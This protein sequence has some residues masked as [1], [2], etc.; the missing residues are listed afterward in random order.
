MGFAHLAAH[1]HR[2]HGACGFANL[3]GFGFFDHFADGV[4]NLAG[5]GVGDHLA[6]HM[7]DHLALFFDLGGPSDTR[8]GLRAIFTLH[9]GMA[10]GV[11]V[12][13]GCAFHERPSVAGA[14]HFA[15]ARGFAGDGVGTGVFVSFAIAIHIR[16]FHDAGGGVGDFLDDLFAFIATGGV[17][18]FLHTLIPIDLAHLARNFLHGAYRNFL[19][20]GVGDFFGLHL[21]HIAGDGD[22]FANRAATE[23]AATSGDGFDRVGGFG[24][25]AALSTLGTFRGIIGNQAGT[26]HGQA[27][28]ARHH[29]VG[30]GDP[31]ELLAHAGF[32]SGYGLANGAANGPGAGFSFGLPLATGDL[33]H[34]VFD[35]H[36]TNIVTDFLGVVLDDWLANVVDNFFGVVFTNLFADLAGLGVS[37][38]FG[39]GFTDGVANGLFALDGDFATHIVTD[40]ALARFD[41]G[42][43][44]GFGFLAIAGLLHRTGYSVFLVEGF[45]VV[46]GFEDGFLNIAHDGF[47]LGFVDRF[48]L[49]PVAGFGNRF[50]RFLADGLV[51]GH[52]P[53]FDLAVPYKLVCW[54]IPLAK[55]GRNA[56]RVLR[57]LGHRGV[58]A[59]AKVR[60][61]GGLGHQ[62]DQ[63]RYPGRQLTQFHG[64]ILL[65]HQAKSS[66]GIG[67]IPE[68][69]SPL[70]MHPTPRRT[71]LG[72]WGWWNI[73]SAQW[74]DQGEP[75]VCPHQQDHFF[76]REGQTTGMIRNSCWIARFHK[77]GTSA[78]VW[79][80]VCKL[81]M[82]H[83]FLRMPT[84][85]DVRP[86]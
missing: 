19:A 26:L 70:C 37:P 85:G 46:A 82:S 21:T 53:L 59:H 79:G 29:G 63:Q 18:D 14:F 24:N 38:G 1:G 17:G 6:G 44:A 52:I 41:F 51:A 49:V 45:G 55:S 39:Y 67:H 60:G 2:F 22:A 74:S 11:G 23:H 66:H 12:F 13:P 77:L 50:G 72:H 58:F 78:R 57:R 36:T 42:L 62:P 5:D 33:F 43:A 8:D 10:G 7:G 32:A 9:V 65:R 40:L 48:D 30:F 31:L 20:D 28:I 54:T 47:P 69:I 84:I 80:I 61:G 15:F 81:P 4:G 27:R 86:V 68:A 16:T 56:A 71:I 64:T 73:L 35:F 25:L 76:H 34:G 3:F 83:D 75:G